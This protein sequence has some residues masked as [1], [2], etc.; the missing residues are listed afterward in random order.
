[1]VKLS[2]CLMRTEKNEVFLVCVSVFFPV[3]R[4]ISVQHLG[5][6]TSFGAALKA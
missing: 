2:G 4:K 5:W 3:R 1:M 6:Q